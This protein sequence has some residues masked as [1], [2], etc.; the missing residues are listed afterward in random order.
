MGP[1]LCSCPGPVTLSINYQQI[2]LVLNSLP[3]IT[4]LT[5]DASYNQWVRGFISFILP[6]L[7][8]SMTGFIV[9]DTVSHKSRYH[10]EHPGRVRGHPWISLR[11]QE[12]GEFEVKQCPAQLSPRT[13]QPR[14]EAQM[15]RPI[16]GWRVGAMLQALGPSS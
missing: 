7:L 1:Q 4:V 6:D 13:G 16:Q 2:P 3:P 5:S 8:L 11:L 10:T 12:M 14:H 9:D 15:E